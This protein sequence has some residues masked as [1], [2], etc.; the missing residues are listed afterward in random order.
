MTAQPVGS[1]HIAE[2]PAIK[3]SSATVRNEM[4]HLEHEGYLIQPHTSAGRIPT[5]K[6]YRYFVDHLTTPGKLD[7]SRTNPSRSAGDEHPLARAEICTVKHVLG[8]SIG[9]GDCC[10]LCIAPVAVDWKDLGCRHLHEFGEGPV[11]V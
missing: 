6:G 9:T 3:V 4:A 2:A 5:D 7:C 10:E 1:S 8:R 11:E